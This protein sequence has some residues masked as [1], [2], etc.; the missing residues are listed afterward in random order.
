LILEGHTRWV[1]Q[2]PQD[3]VVAHLLHPDPFRLSPTSLQRL[4]EAGQAQQ[5]A[6]MMAQ[7][8]RLFPAL[9]HLL[10]HP[11]WSVRLGAMVA[12]ETLAETNRTLA[13]E[14]QEPIWQAMARADATVQGDLL[15]VIGAIGGPETLERLQVLVDGLGDEAV[16]EAATEALERILKET[17]PKFLS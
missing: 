16:K 5:V 7:S 12:A 13:G 14:L 10:A 6:G 3:E 11:R 17:Q 1:G 2:V 8:G 4:L 9:I 15:Y